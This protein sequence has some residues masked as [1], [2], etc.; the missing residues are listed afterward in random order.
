[1]TQDNAETDR[2]QRETIR[3]IAVQTAK[4]QSSWSVWNVGAAVFS[5]K[6]TLL[7]LWAFGALG[8]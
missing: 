2:I 3:K 8:G 7:L 4:L 6:Y 5:A 1:M